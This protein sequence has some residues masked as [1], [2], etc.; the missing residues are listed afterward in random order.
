MLVG[1][2]S[3]SRLSTLS[4]SLPEDATV[5]EPNQADAAIKPI[6]TAKD[7]FMPPRAYRSVTLIGLPSGVKKVILPVT[8]VLRGLIR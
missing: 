8:A 1:C 3:V 5:L 6:A 7:A 2:A 4:R